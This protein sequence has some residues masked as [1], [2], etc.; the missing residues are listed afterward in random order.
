MLRKLNLDGDGQADLIGHGGEFKA[1]YVYST[2]N[3]TYWK[4]ELGKTDFITGQFGEKFTVEGMPDD[5]ICVG[6]TFR[7]GSLCSMI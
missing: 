2:E 6:D 3:Y 1:A 4:Q 5:G 7:I